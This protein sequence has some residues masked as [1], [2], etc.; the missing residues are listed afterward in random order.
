M[1]FTALHAPD[2][3]CLR[4]EVR[5]GRSTVIP[6]EHPDG[7]GWLDVL[8][9]NGMAGNAD[10]TA[11]VR[12]LRLWPP[13]GASHAVAEA[14]ATSRFDASLRNLA[15][16]AYPWLRDDFITLLALLGVIRDATVHRRDRL[17]QVAETLWF[18]GS[19]SLEGWLSCLSLGHI[20]AAI[21]RA[22]GGS[23]IP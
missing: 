1:P 2:L 4:T 20:Q 6:F 10:A 5:A 11:P 18:V 19:P 23:E 8:G 16:C 14:I 15:E 12:T 9:P 17:P 22:S 13:G 21:L 3:V 7:T